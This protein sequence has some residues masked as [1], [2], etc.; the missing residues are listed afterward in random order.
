MQ[1]QSAYLGNR[2]ECFDAVDL[3]VRGLV[4]AHLDEVEQLRHARHG[5]ALKEMLTADAVGRPHQR[6]GATRQ[7]RQHPLCC[8]LIVAG[9]VEFGDRLAVARIRPERLLGLGY[10]NAEYR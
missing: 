1:F 9:E 5:V 10:R 8:L 4:A 3:H 2:G 7:V 6:T